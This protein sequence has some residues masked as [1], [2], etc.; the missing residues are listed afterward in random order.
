MGISR[1]FCSLVAVILIQR[2]RTCCFRMH[3]RFSNAGRMQNQILRREILRMTGTLKKIRRKALEKRPLL[4]IL[5][6]DLDRFAETQ[7][8]YFETSR[9]APETLSYGL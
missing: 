6:H 4:V 2:R 3:Q 1:Y 9:L 8:D 5:R 7:E